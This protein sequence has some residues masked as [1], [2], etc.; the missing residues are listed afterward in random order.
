MIS[1]ERSKEVRIKRA[2]TDWWINEK[3]VVGANGLNYIVYVTDM[4][5]IHIKEFDAKCSRTPSRDV[6]LCRMNCTYA[7]EHNAPSLCILENGKIMVTY[8]GHAQNHTL[9]FRITENPYDIMSFGGEHILTYDSNVTYAQVFENVKR[10]EI[11][12]F[13]RVK[14][15]TW[16]F[17]YSK[18]EGETWSTPNTFLKSDAGGLFYFDM[19]KQLVPTAE[20][21]GEQWFFALYGHP[22]ISKDHTI[23]S[24]IFDADGFLLTQDGEKTDVNL[25]DAA[26][27]EINLNELAVVY[28]SPEGTTVRL[29]AVSATL[30]FRVGLAAFTLDRADTITYYAAEYNGGKWV[31]SKPIA[32]G[33]EFLAPNQ[34][35]GS[36]TYVGG[37][38]F[39][40]GV[41][42]AGFN[43]ADG[44]VIDTNRL[45]VA[46]ADDENRVLESYVSNDCGVSYTL[47]QTIR[48]IPK[49]ENKKIW[50][51]TVPI[52]AQDNLPVYW[53]EGSYSA[54]TG[55]WH[56]DEVMF[57][58]YDD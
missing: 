35:D 20:G 9:R 24:G 57:V 5:E 12:L 42:E 37:M 48:K 8:T 29:L 10:K 21:V 31:L 28:E 25:F 17:R 50:R 6:C 3:A 26:K 46:R 1:I 43:I 56:C 33:G 51:P 40:Y 45:Y 54:H 7:D 52:Y 13:A 44:G 41:G 39:Y 34:T 38:A 22:R 23:R 32:S 18:D 27:S 4:G 19:R 47:E 30:P 36:Q 53:H 2:N 58:E 16:E 49:R 55:G 15:V 14:S 11:W